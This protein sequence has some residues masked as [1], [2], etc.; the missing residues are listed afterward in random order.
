MSEELEEGRGLQ[1]D[2]NKLESIAANGCKVVPVAVQNA[3]DGQVIMI[4]Y[5]NAHALAEAQRLHRAVFWSTSRNELWI[6]G[7]S[8]G[9]VLELIEIRTNCEQNSLLYSVRPVG[10]GACH[11]QLPDG[12]H[13]PSC[14]YRRLDGD[15]LEDVGGPPAFT[16]ANGS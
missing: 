4:G 12:T 5:V 15:R 1:L 14:Y 3:D 11:T 2:F 7:A 10:S 8:S 16:Q 6:K 9:H 13:R